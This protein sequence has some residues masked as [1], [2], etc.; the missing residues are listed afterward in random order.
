MIVV[1]KLS[2]GGWHVAAAAKNLA[3]LMRVP[4]MTRK[5]PRLLFALVAAGLTIATSPAAASDLKTL[6]GQLGVGCKNRVIEQFD[7][8]SSDITVRLGATLQADL[9]SGVMSA[10]ELKEYGASFD[11]SV[12]GK[13]DGGY[14]NVD[15]KG[16]VTE[17]KQW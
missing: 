1:D 12:A 3:Q 14:C 2:R 6:I 16:K 8:P 4:P 5:L 17:F 11:W 15:G 10:K 7:V 9:D 13:D